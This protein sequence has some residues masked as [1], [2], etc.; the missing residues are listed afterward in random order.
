STPPPNASPVSANTRARSSS[1][2]TSH[3]VTSGLPTSPAS[4]RTFSSIRSPWYVKASVAPP[5]ASR[6]AIAHA[7]ER[8]LATPKTRPVF[9]STFI[10]GLYG[11]SG[12]LGCLA[13]HLHP[14][15][16]GGAHGRSCRDGGL[17]A[18]PARLR[19]AD[20]STGPRWHDRRVAPEA[21]H[22]D[23]RDRR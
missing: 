23:A 20:V 9:P 5:S 6:L 13:P 8:L 2:R 3:A 17:S 15:F 18:G 12:P 10:R 11:S 1:E 19:G 16:A 7:I 22:P 4:A 14:R 21:E